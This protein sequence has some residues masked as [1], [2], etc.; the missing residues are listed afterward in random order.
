MGKQE[1]PLT[2]KQ[3]KFCKY[4]VDTEGNASEAY[5]MS[6]DASKMKPE[7]IWSAASRLLA[8]SKVSARISEIKQQM[9]IVLADPD[10]LHYVDPVTGK[11]KMR[12][13]SQ[14]PKRARNALKKIQNNR[15]VVNYEFNGKTEA[16]RILGAWNGW[17]ADKNVNIKGGDGNKVGE[18]RIGFEDNEN[19]EE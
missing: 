5:R 7:T 3:E 9:D 12:S 10:D 2:F 18:L 1:K 11:T 15:G 4:Y 17:E 6:Y 14:L 16:A 8:N 19:S 13:P